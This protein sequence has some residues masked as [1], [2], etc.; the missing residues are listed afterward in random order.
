M[1][2]RHYTPEEDRVIRILF[3]DYG[4]SETRMNHYSRRF[5]DS[6]RTYRAIR[7]RNNVLVQ[8]ETW[9]QATGGNI[10]GFVDDDG[11]V[12]IPPPPV[13]SS[14]INDN[15]F[16]SLVSP[17]TASRF[18]DAIKG[19]KRGRPLEELEGQL[20]KF[21][22]AS[23]KRRLEIEEEERKRQEEE[24]A[25]LNDAT[26]AGCIVCKDEECQHG[27]MMTKCGHTMCI[28]CTTNLLTQPLSYYGQRF[29]RCP[30]CRTELDGVGAINPLDK[31]S[32]NGDVYKAFKALN[33]K[34]VTIVNN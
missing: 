3:T 29:H 27:V 31:G 7:E 32:T 22:E 30:A 34:E 18:V 8:T 5:P 1:R 10:S 2:G 26:K 20:E 6:T 17:E 4:D 33:E 21:L 16:N 11:V 19:I 13:V 9:N 12:T 24:E 14:T 15:V 25:K 23:K 28:G